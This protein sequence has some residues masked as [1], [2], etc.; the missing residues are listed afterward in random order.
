MELR[1]HFMAVY[2]FREWGEEPVL[3][4]YLRAVQFLLSLVFSDFLSSVYS[5]SFVQLLV[6]ILPKT[7]R[8][9]AA[10]DLCCAAVSSD[11]TGGAGSLE[12]TL[13]STVKPANSWV[14]RH[15][16]TPLSC[17]VITPSSC[18]GS[19]SHC[20]MPVLLNKHPAAIWFTAF[21]FCR[22]NKSEAISGSF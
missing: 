15:A 13:R 9:A 16:L 5:C 12:G 1:G 8:K 19:K 20:H 2:G 10:H 22:S 6:F 11:A 21:S 3:S 18:F 4:Q 14:S 7:T 17:L